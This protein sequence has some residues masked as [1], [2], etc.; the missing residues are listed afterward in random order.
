MEK[1]NKS[2]RIFQNGSPASEKN[3]QT[4][5]S[6]GVVDYMGVRKS[7][8]LG[9]KGKKKNLSALKSQCND[10]IG[11]TNLDMDGMIYCGLLELLG[12]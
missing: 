3:K 5:R 4:C 12:E 8:K 7:K 6:C 2:R 10:Y 1:N 9:R 11:Y